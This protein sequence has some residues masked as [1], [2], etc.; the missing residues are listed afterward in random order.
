MEGLQLGDKTQQ[1][2]EGLE[3]RIIRALHTHGW[4]A[5]NVGV[6]S[7]DTVYLS[8]YLSIDRSIHHLSL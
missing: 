6:E 3:A 4:M 5:G 7:S 8:I 2:S 1:T